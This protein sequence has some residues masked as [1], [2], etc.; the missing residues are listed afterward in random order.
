MT[1]HVCV[2]H[3]VVKCLAE[4]AQEHFGRAID[5]LERSGIVDA[6]RGC[7]GGS[8]RGRARPCLQDKLGDLHRPTHVEVDHLQFGLEIGL[9][10]GAPRP[11]PAF[12]QEGFDLSPREGAVEAIDLGLLRKVCCVVFDPPPIRTGGCR[13]REVRLVLRDD[14]DVVAILRNC[15]TSSK[16]MPLDPP[17]TTAKGRVLVLLMVLVSCIVWA[18]RSLMPGVP[19]GARRECVVGC[20]RHA[21]LDTAVP[22][23]S[24]RLIGTS[25]STPQDDLAQGNPHEVRF[26]ARRGSDRRDRSVDRSNSHRRQL[27]LPRTPRDRQAGHD[28]ARSGDEGRSRQASGARPKPMAPSPSRRRARARPPPTPPW[29]S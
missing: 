29:L 5:G 26:L 14:Q 9:H 13:V 15:R 12:T 20:I 1:G 6:D 23:Y 28:A 4:P 7:L 25:A 16:P 22:S 3:L 18:N 19:I 17:V 8:C 24:P 21:A 2:H 11:T 10:K 27:P